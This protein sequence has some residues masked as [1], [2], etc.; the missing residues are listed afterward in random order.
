MNKNVKISKRLL[1]CAKMVT[2]KGNIAD[3]GTDHAYLPIYLALTNKIS[4]AIACDIH[5]EPLN[6][7]KS[8]V[9]LF[10]LENAVEVRQSDGL[11]NIS[12][13]EADTVVIAG[14]GG[15]L[16]AK[17]LKDCKW[18]NKKDKEFIFQPMKYE[19]NLRVYL[20][21]MGYE[22]KKE[23]AVKC[24]GKV[25]T[26]IKANYTAQPYELT[27][28]QVYIGFLPDHLNDDAKCYIRKQL[29]DLYNRIK[30]AIAKGLKDQEAY[31]LKIIKK[32][33]K[34]L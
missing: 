19:N 14:M 12:S 18:E 13:S 31:Y 30:G 4:H 1:K 21:K 3:V 5:K 23:I 22:I 28:T 17:I 9:K 11:K 15:N 20:S 16:I 10:N 8:N 33:K 34:L 2:S 24:S 7:A 25:Y 26:V 27:P 29:N 32:L 6:N